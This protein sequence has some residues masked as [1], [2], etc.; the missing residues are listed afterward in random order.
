MLKLLEVIQRVT[1]PYPGL[2]IVMRLDLTDN[3]ETERQEALANAR[4]LYGSGKIYRWHDCGHGIGQPF[5]EQ[6]I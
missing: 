2:E 6:D 1:L 3:T 5:T 4:I